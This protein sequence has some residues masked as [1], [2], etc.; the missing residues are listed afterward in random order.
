ML[1]AALAFVLEAEIHAIF[2]PAVIKFAFA[3]PD[4]SSD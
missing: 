4:L 2:L 1:V 3:F